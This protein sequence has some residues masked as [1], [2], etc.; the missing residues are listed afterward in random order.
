MAYT[1]YF[2]DLTK[3]KMKLLPHGMFGALIL[4]G[5]GC[6]PDSKSQRQDGNHDQILAAARDVIQSVGKC[7]LITIDENGQPQA[8]TMDP[9]LPED[10]FTIWLATN[11]K[12]RKVSHIKNNSSVTLYYAD[13]ND[14]GYVSVYGV[15]E[16][17]TDQQEKDKRWKEE[18]KKFY[19]DRSGSYLLIKVIPSR[20]EVINYSRDLN[21]NSETWQPAVVFFN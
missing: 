19:P 17:V 7:A 12:S 15:A 2:N 3:L 21:G 1:L 16:L 10:D 5:V 11:P 13:K 9:F 8:R 20:I 14:N 6:T 18:W 4:I